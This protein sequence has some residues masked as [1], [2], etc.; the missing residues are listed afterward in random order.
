VPR[1]T[2]WKALT[3][4]AEN[5]SRPIS[6]ALIIYIRPFIGWIFLQFRATEWRIGAHPAGNQKMSAL[7]LEKGDRLILL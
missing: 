1:S 2:G 5:S 3:I 7:P 6:E 4:I